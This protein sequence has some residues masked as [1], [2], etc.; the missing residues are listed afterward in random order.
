MNRTHYQALRRTRRGPAFALLADLPAALLPQHLHRLKAQ[1]D[2][3]VHHVTVE[4]NRSIN[5]ALK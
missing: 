2:F 4:R 3:A 1:V 5:P